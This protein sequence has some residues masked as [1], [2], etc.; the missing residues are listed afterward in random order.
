MSMPT[1]DD[2]DG[3]LAAELLILASGTRL[4]QLGRGIAIK[5]HDSGKVR[6][7]W[8]PHADMQK[9]TGSAVQAAC[10]GGAKAGE[11]Q[12]AKSVLMQVHGAVDYGPQ[13]I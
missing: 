3:H 10:P 13:H 8:M 2:G 1:R 9:D 12:V 6:K 7:A 11:L 4:N 5:I